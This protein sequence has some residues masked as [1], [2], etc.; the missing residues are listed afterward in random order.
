MFLLFLASTVLILL[1][2]KLLSILG[3]LCALFV[4][5][6]E[7]GIVEEARHWRARRVGVREWECNLNVR[8]RV[9]EWVRG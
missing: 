6:I 3:P 7:L 8:K 4:L 1:T 5:L 2:A 9:A